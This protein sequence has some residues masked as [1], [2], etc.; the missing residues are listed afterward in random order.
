MVKFPENFIQNI[1]PAERD[2][3]QFQKKS[4]LHYFGS[5]PFGFFMVNTLE[6]LNP[7]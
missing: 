4:L 2:T 3:I 6:M 1:F 7:K 5:K